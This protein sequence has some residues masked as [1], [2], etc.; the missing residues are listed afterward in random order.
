[1]NRRAFL[2]VSA[3]AASVNAVA[4]TP[5]IPII[6][7]HIHLFDT[8]R[9]GIPYP[10]K[11]NAVLYKPALPSRYRKIIAPFRVS[12]AI[13]VECSNRFE[14]NQWL[15]DTA[16]TDK[17]I[18]GVVGNLEPEKP[19]FTKQ[20][21]QF[22]RNPLFLGFR[23]GNL[24]SRNLGTSLSKPEFLSGLKALADSGLELDTANPEPPLVAAVVRLTDLVPTLRVVVDHMPRW[25]PLDDASALATYRANLRELGK[26]PQVYVKVS[27][28]LRR[29]E[30]KVPTDLNFYREQLDELWDIFGQN[31]LIY[32]SDWPNG[33][34]WAEYPEVFA[35]V[36][37]YFTAKGPAVAEK[38]FWKNSVAAYR[39]VKRDPSQPEPGKA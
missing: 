27:E 30:G 24:W 31:R 6:D 2:S 25:E 7:A 9:E 1:V 11:N 20:L 36:R 16:A 32:G 19:D 5:S 39:W 13:A 14:D 12:G 21:E 18:V 33:D 38:F 3:A 17:I 37:E 29:I 35:V 10:N 34:Q 4:Q 22:H 8:T 26:R 15:L 28:V 23:S